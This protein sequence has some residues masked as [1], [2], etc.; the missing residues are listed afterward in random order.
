MKFVFEVKYKHRQIYKIIPPLLPPY[1]LRAKKGQ[2]K[3]QIYRRRQCLA[4]LEVI[5]LCF[6]R[7]IL[8]GFFIWIVCKHGKYCKTSY[9]QQ[10][11]VH[12]KSACMGFI[13]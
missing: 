9:V 7:K 2:Q 4:S 8:C 1:G 6:D 13:N 11:L 5:S 12:A 3:D 10:V